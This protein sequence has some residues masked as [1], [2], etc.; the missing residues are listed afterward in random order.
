M[1]F[2]LNGIE[3]NRNASEQCRQGVEVALDADLKNLKKGDL[4]FFGRRATRRGPERI[5]HAGIYLGDKL[6]IHSSESVH[7]SSLDPA[8]PLR[9]EPRIR[10][11]LHA[12]RLLPDS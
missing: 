9:D 6:F 2:F 8:S 10:L 12:R 3:L 5:G 4:L 1:V 11:L 7:L